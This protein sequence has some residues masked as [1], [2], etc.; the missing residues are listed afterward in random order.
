M[1]GAAVLVAKGAKLSEEAIETIRHLRY[2]QNAE[3]GFVLFSDR[4]V[5]IVDVGSIDEMV[6]KARDEAGTVLGSMPD[7]APYNMDDGCGLLHMLNANVYNFRPYEV[8]TGSLFPAMELRQEC[9]DACEKCEMIAIVYC[10]ADDY[11]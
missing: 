2:Y 3:G 6:D 10:D 5:A 7:F 11:E 9:L 4:V 1:I 8:N